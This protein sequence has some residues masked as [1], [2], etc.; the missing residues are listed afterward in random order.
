MHVESSQI[1]TNRQRNGKIDGMS[2]SA[3]TVVM[4]HHRERAQRLDRVAPLQMAETVDP[5]SAFPAASAT[6][7]AIA[8]RSQVSNP[9]G[10]VKKACAAQAGHH[11]AIAT[12]VIGE[13]NVASDNNMSSQARWTEAPAPFLL[14][15]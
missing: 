11:E 15:G 7:Q 3:R 1:I 13:R 6:Q 4:T 5:Q 2:G 12:Q 10:S 8:A 9:A 14:L